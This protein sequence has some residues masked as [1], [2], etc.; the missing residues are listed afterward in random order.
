RPTTDVKSIKTTLKFEKFRP[1]IDTNFRLCT[2]TQQDVTLQRLD[3]QPILAID[4]GIGRLRT[5]RH[6]LLHLYNITSY[7]LFTEELKTKFSLLDQ[8]QF[9]TLVQEKFNQIDKFL[10]IL[11]NN[12]QKRWDRIG[13][14][15]KT[16]A[17][18][19]DADDLRMINSSI[20]SLITNN[21]IQIKIN[22]DL[23]LQIK[24]ALEKT[25]EAINLVNFRN[26][27]LFSIN[28]FM[29]LKF[30]SDKLEQI[31]DS[32]T[33]AKVKILN[34]KILS[35]TEIDCIL[36][37]VHKE[38]LLTHTIAETLTYATPTLATHHGNLA[39]LIKLPKL[40][41]R[42]YKKLRIFPIQNHQVL[43][44][45]Q[46][47]YLYHSDEIRK[48]RSLDPVVFD[49][50]ESTVDYSSCIPELLRGRPARCNLT[51]NPSME[52]IVRID[53]KHIL[54]NSGV[55]VSFATDC[56][57]PERKISGSFLI[58]FKNCGVIINH[59]TYLNKPQI[60]SGERLR[61]P[62]D[63]V[64]ITFHDTVVNLSMRHLLELNLERRREIESLQLKTDSMTWPN[65]SLLGGVAISPYI[66]IALLFLSFLLY[67]RRHPAHHTHDG[68][69]TTSTI[70][71]RTEQ[72]NSTT[73]RL[74]EVLFRSKSTKAG[75]VNDR[76]N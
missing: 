27:D 29:N 2:P 72:P 10:H 15:W 17:G 49:P 59:E 52:K 25:K 50:E 40:D 20:N 38:N 54:I 55:N 75:V 3:G 43:H 14:F 76:A 6:Y 13:T 58:T 68:E 18:N 37:I 44:L 60:L 66:I 39:L 24:E 70:P 28:I 65:W 47:F 63:G 35:Q 7:Q 69:P 34:E 32:I 42:P 33:L 23:H 71:T 41:P 73:Q 48:V 11:L 19:P 21:N 5:G 53:D 4:Y 36:E 26:S 22:R 56:G 9:T 12:R 74:H 8:N 57:D 45:E 30:L 61:I 1:K 62:L 16:I 51:G 64:K 31:I 67:R 46:E